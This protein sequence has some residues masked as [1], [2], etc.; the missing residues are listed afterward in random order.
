MTAPS[1]ATLQRW[2]VIERL[3]KA[4]RDATGPRF[5]RQWDNVV[6]DLADE[7]MRIVEEARGATMQPSAPP[8]PLTGGDADINVRVRIK[9]DWVPESAI[10]GLVGTLTRYDRYGRAEVREDG[11]GYYLVPR[12]QIERAPAQC[13]I[14]G[15]VQVSR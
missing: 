11:G 5:D 7:V 15:A 14:C 10:S 4:L 6:T 8:E 2:G 1:E 3:R 13:P 12:N 9:R